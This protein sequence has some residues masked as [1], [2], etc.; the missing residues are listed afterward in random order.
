[1]N[2]PR[3]YRWNL[4]RVAGFA[5]LTAALSGA[6]SADWIDYTKGFTSAAGLSVT[7]AAR[8][9]LVWDSVQKGALILTDT[10]RGPNSA[11]PE[12]RSS[13][14]YATPVSIQRFVTSFG[15]QIT[16][17]NREMADGITFTI[18]NAGPNAL[19]GPGGGMGYGP[20]PGGAT[21]PSIGHSVAVKFDTYMNGG[22][23]STG[24]TG[25]AV[26]GATPIGG[27][28]LAKSGIDLLSGHPFRADISYTLFTLTVKLTDLATSA[29]DL[30]NY[31]VNIPSVVGGT[32]AYVGFT[33]STGGWVSRH[34]ITSWGF[35]SGALVP[36]V[37]S[38]T[39]SPN[40]ACGG[41]PSTGLV[42]L[43]EAMAT[44]TI[45][46]IT[47][48][49]AAATTPA[50]VV[51]PAGSLSASFPITTKVVAAATPGSISVARDKAMARATLTV[52]PIGVDVVSVAADYVAEGAS[53]VGT[54]NLQLPAAPGAVTVNLVSA[55]PGVASVPVSVTIPQGSKTAQ[56][57][58]DTFGVGANTPC[59]ITAAANGSRRTTTLTVRPL[60]VSAV[61]LGVLSVKSGWS[62]TGTLSLE[63]PAPAGGVTMNLSSNYAAVEVPATVFFAAG[64][65][66]ATFPVMAGTVGAKT[67]VTVAASSRVNNVYSKVT[68]EP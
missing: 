64:S 27:T 2:Q 9:P 25:I 56:F 45:F 42:T 24:C 26:N 8:Y 55:V 1:M 60:R 31:T 18:Q 67:L 12:E 35:Q 6:A 3:A 7:Q 11:G 23:P 29:T 37:R 66:S 33:A 63:A 58:I 13:A 22:D 49:N 46:Q 53:T 39:V 36:A 5:L 10:Q 30:Q 4:C 15:F 16:A 51:I 62:G 38:F 21:S 32:T 47:S 54:I 52:A 57:K 44:D 48:A 40:P 34:A 65:T 19:G 43:Q 41:I 68:V 28:D 61:S 14:F 20:A 59:L 50:T 17:N